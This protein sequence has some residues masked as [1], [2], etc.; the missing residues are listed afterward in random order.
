MKRQQG[1]VLVVGMLLLLV[2]TMIALG[3]A[4]NTRSSNQLSAASLARESAMHRI[5]GAQEKFFEQQRLARE[6]SLLVTTTDSVTVNDTEYNV[7]NRA[8]FLVETGCRRTRNA[9][10]STVMGCRQNEV[11]TTVRFGKNQRGQLAATTGVE[12]PVLVASGG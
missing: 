11:S 10:S 12:Q 7:D 8:S 6:A 4:S 2:L 9:T 3:L 5:N 1:L